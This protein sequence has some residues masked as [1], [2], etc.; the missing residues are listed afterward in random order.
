VFKGLMYML[1]KAVK[2]PAYIRLAM[3]RNWAEI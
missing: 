3:S 2:L 1:I